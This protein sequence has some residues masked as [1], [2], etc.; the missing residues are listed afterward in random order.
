MTPILKKPLTYLRCR[1]GLIVLPHKLKPTSLIM[2]RRSRLLSHITRV[3]TTLKFSSALTSLVQPGPPLPS[4]LS[5]PL[6]SCCLFFHCATKRRFLFKGVHKVFRN[7]L[8]RHSFL[9]EVL[10][11]R[12]DF[13]F[14][15]FAN[16][17]HLPLLKV[18]YIRSQA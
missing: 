3:C 6:K 13:K 11:K 16:V 4:T 12:S 5:L 14:L 17:S 18:F 7:F 9:S 10:D 8:W 1:L 2:L 15:H